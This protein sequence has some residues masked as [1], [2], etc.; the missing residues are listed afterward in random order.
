MQAL[1]EPQQQ[2]SQKTRE[3]FLDALEQALESKS[4]NEISVADLAEIAGRSVGSFYTKFVDKED[5]LLQLFSRYEEERAK[6][7]EHTF[8]REA[9]DGMSLEETVWCICQISVREF[10]TRRGLLKAFFQHFQGA[11]ITHEQRQ[12]LVPLYDSVAEILLMH[13]DRIDHPDPE[14]AARFSFFLLTSVC[15][16]A[17]LFGEGTHARSLQLTPDELSRQCE[18]AMLGYLL[19]GSSLCS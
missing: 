1:K 8:A 15:H 3:A 14:A 17:L 10:V 18:A 5:L 2:R 19:N 9:W 12:K 11:T 6:V 16:M 7:G 13:K 4:V